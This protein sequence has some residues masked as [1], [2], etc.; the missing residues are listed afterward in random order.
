MLTKLEIIGDRSEYIGKK[1][2]YH[3]ADYDMVTNPISREKAFKKLKDDG[4]LPSIP[5]KDYVSAV[6]VGLRENQM[7]LDLNYE[8]DSQ[9]DT[10]MNFVMTGSGHFVEIQG[11]AEKTPFTKHQMDEMTDFAAKGCRELIDYQKRIVE[12]FF[13]I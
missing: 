6:S 8:E 10:D 11:T 12:K 3:N 7:L 2:H 4:I 1:G 13:T 5:L 9:V